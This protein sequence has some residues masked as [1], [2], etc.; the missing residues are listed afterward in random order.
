MRVLRLVQGSVL[1]SLL[2]VA[3]LSSGCLSKP[4]LKREAFAFQAPTTEG[5]Q[6]AGPVVLV[7]PVVVSPLYSGRPFTYRI[8]PEGYETDPYAGFLIAPAQSISIAIQAHLLGSGRFQ[9]VVEPGSGV[10]V[11]KAISVYVTELCGDFSESG[12][13]AAVLSLRIT[14]M[15]PDG[16][17]QGGLQKSYSR[18]VSLTANTAAAVMAGWDKALSEIMKEAAADLSGERRP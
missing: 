8:S 16:E 13:S 10:K 12:K 14:S 6:K 1:L 5:V 15:G 9:D 3:L 7:H 2:L 11:D 17:R 18:R 4:S